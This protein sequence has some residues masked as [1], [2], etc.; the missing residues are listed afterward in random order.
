[1][2]KENPASFDKIVL[3]ITPGQE[4]KV[5]NKDLAKQNLIDQA[6]DICKDIA[7]S[8]SK[9]LTSPPSLVAPAM[10]SANKAR[11]GGHGGI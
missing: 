3:G 4:G 9:A 7:K 2:R 6:K 1:M 8:P 5:S 10:A 11:G